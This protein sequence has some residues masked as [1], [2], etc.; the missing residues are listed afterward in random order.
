[1]IRNK[2]PK[3][4]VSPDFKIKLYDCYTKLEKGIFQSADEAGAAEEWTNLLNRGGLCHVR[5]NIS[6]N[7]FT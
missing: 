3:I 4:S 6:A 7:V 1:M 5:D 2:I